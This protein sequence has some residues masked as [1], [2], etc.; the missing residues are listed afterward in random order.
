VH[1]RVQLEML[2]LVLS[3][4]CA[5]INAR[6]LALFEPTVNECFV[7]VCG[8]FLILSGKCMHAKTE[9]RR[10]ALRLAG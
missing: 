8:T 1:S 3:L 9:S 4:Q 6:S 7:V 2:R 5:V 10:R